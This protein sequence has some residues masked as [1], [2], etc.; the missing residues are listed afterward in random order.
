MFC[1]WCLV[2]PPSPTLSATCPAVQIQQVMM[3][4]EPLVA[5]GPVNLDKTIQYNVEVFYLYVPF[6]WVHSHDGKTQFFRNGGK[7]MENDRKLTGID[8]R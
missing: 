2:Q 6:W 1:V 5:D 7:L 4:C 8:G 3:W